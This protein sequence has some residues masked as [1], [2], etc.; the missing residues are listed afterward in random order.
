MFLITGVFGFLQPFVPLY[1]TGSGLSKQQ[2]G[3]VTAIG[4]GLALLVQPILGRLSDR[5]DARRPFMVLAA[6]CAGVAYLSYRSAHGFWAFVAL[7]AVGVNGFSYLNSVGGVLVGRIARASG[8]GAAYVGY[9]VWGSVG[10]I[11]IATGAGLL[12]SGGNAASLARAQL[13]P[14]FTYGPLLFF[15][16]AVVALLVPDAKALTPGPSPRLGRGVPDAAGSPAVA[17]AS[18]SSSP[19]P[20]LGEGPGVRATPTRGAKLSN[21]DW[22][23]IAYFLY[24]FGL[25]GASAYLSLYMKALGAKPLWITGMFAAG[26]ICEVLVMTRVGRWT[27]RHGRRPALLASFLLMP[28]RLLLYIPA[29]G[30]LWVLLVQSLHGINFGIVGTIAIVFVNDHADD[31]NRGTLQARLAA[32]AGIAGAISPLLCG[33]IADRY[34]IGTMFAAMSVVGFAAAYLMWTRV[35]ESL[36]APEPLRGPLRRLA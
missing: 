1:V 7:T 26:V 9:R 17:V 3:L 20:S 19:L 23:L 30:P 34:G 31:T 22:F 10:Y 6:C 11:V 25:Y 8:G 27:D 2:Y 35:R 5:F 4:T 14:L 15:V 16:I 12:V 24:Q 13:E 33:W 28:I 18:A 32:T 21:L 36:P 29:T